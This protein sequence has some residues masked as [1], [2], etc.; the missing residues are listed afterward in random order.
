M[1]PLRSK[2]KGSGFMRW[3]KDYRLKNHVCFRHYCFALAA[4]NARAAL[5]ELVSNS[6]VLADGQGHRQTLSSQ[7]SARL[8]VARNSSSF[9]TIHLRLPAPLDDA[10]RDAA[11]AIG[12]Q[13]SE[14]LRHLI[15]T[16]TKCFE[17]AP[18]VEAASTR[19][20]VDRSAAGD[21]AALNEMALRAIK[22]VPTSDH[23]RREALIIAT[24][25]AQLAAAHGDVDAVRRLAQLQM[26]RAKEAWKDGDD[27]LASVF[28]V[29]A[30]LNLETAANAG[31]ESAAHEL[32]NY[33]ASLPA[34]V[35][36]EAVTCVRA[37][38][39]DEEE[40]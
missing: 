7:T 11:Q 15:R 16:S 36:A 25:Y 12:M 9:R 35:L 32:S 5:P 27:E 1:P 28:G 26:V 22:V 31:S 24:V 3:H 17:A 20:L 8:S 33:A 18:A 19:E 38:Q 29:E 39:A 23:Q 10:V 4:Q 37:G 34:E 21:P 13:R 40:R 2:N 30:V 14:Y 6:A